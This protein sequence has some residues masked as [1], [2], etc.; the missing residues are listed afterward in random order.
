MPQTRRAPCAPADKRRLLFQ[1]LAAEVLEDLLQKDPH[2]FY[3]PS[4]L[5]R[6]AL[7]LGDARS[8]NRWFMR[9]TELCGDGA[10][11]HPCML[12]NNGFLAI[13]KSKHAGAHRVC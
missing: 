8:A 9:A 4:A 10:S 13:S 11:E 3:I 2:N 5:G 1:V 6:L 12:M 7:Y